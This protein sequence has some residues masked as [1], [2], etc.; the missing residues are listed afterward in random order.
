VQGP[1]ILKG[2]MVFVRKGKAGVLIAFGGYQTAY[3]GV[4]FASWPWD[5]RPFSDIFIYDIFSSTWYR[6][7]AV[8]DLPELRT[9]FCAGVSSAPD[10]SSFQITI[11]G[12]WD[13]LRGRAFNDV[14]VL[15][16]P[17][18]RWIKVQ[19]SNNPDLLGPDEPGRNR[20]KCDVFNETS[21]IVTGGTVTFG[22]GD[23]VSLSSRG[24]N[25]TYP[26]IKVL[27]TS[28]YTW[29]AQFDPSLSYSVPSVVTA[30]IGGK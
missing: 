13:Q 25:A 17:S 12:G 14:Y 7:T 1:D 23:T 2:A 6:Q 11:H 20:H 27:D 3:E 21:L 24:C 10:D 15:S 22:L 9:E 29:R 28:T 8:G 5:R 19:D 26:P 30:V 16:V 18:F 4:E